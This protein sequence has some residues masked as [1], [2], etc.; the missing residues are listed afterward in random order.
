MKQFDLLV[1]SAD[2]R[3]D[4]GIGRPNLVTVYAE[5]SHAD[6]FGR[7][8]LKPAITLK[9]CGELGDRKRD[10]ESRTA[11]LCLVRHDLAIVPF[12]DRVNN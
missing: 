11:A 4:A 5:L 7:G 1:D 10:S 12:D 8:L 9:N 6:S 2:G 3:L